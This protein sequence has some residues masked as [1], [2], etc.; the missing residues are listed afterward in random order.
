MRA[1][2]SLLWSS[3]VGLGLL[4]TPC[5]AGSFD[6]QGNFSFAPDASF[7]Q[8][9]ESFTPPDSSIAVKSG[10]DAVDGTHYITLVGGGTFHPAQLA[11]EWTA[12]VDGSFTPRL[13][14]RGSTIF[15]TAYAYY[16][17]QSP[18]SLSVLFPT[19]LVSSDGWYELA[20]AP[21][22]IRGTAHPHVTLLLLGRGVDVDAFELDPAGEA[23]PAVSCSGAF[24]PACSAT[25]FCIAGRCR[26][27]ASFV[28]PLPSQ[29]TDVVA[30]SDYL[31]SRIQLV[32][33][34][35]YTRANTMPLALRTLEATAHATDPWSFWNG[36]ITAVHQL[37]DWHTTTTM[38]QQLL[39]GAKV[40][41]NACFVEGDADLSQS[42]EPS[43]SGLADVLV[44]HALPTG[45]DGLKPGDRLVAVDGMHPI[46]WAESL[47]AIDPTY[48]HADDPGTHAE[49]VERLDQLIPL[50]ASTLTTISCEPTGS[51][52][53]PPQTVAVSSLTPVDPT[54]QTY[55]VCDH[56]PGYHLASGNPDSTT[57]D[58]T[59]PEYHGLLADSMPGENLYGM[60]FNDVNLD[61]SG[62]NPLTGAVMDLQ[63]NASGVILDHR[64]GNG[65][66]Q[67]M[68]Q[69]LTQLYRPQS[70]IAVTAA[71][72]GTVGWYDEPFTT[73]DG[74]SI[75]DTFENYGQD[76]YTV[77]SPMALTKLPVALLLARDGSASDWWPLG[78]KGG[79]AN[80]RLF[81][82]QTAG[83]FSTFFQF[84]YFGM[85]WQLASGD[86]IMSD[87]STRLGQAVQPDE[88]LL[89]KQSDLLVGKDTVYERALA[90]VRSCKLGACQ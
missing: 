25:Q 81:G 37:H 64:T 21:F 43:T 60:I 38:P 80:I 61:S 15:A 11:M 74:M 55:I 18:G 33:G 62:N 29:P 86:L 42:I 19:G 68:A 8:G 36:F 76:L 14:A 5:H 16:D 22:T 31:A 46:A 77:G 79:G 56:R 52:C 84:R 13:F 58:L 27:G 3:I 24:D 54:H 78:M 88:V 39:L 49:A 34:G 47:E 17:D 51:T 6:A 57:H 66:V 40:Q 73:A 35:R 23:E 71:P 83:A 85:S 4:S 1:R 20:G 82:R 45:N 30:A 65:G 28:P 9:F 12:Q 26:D 32:F 87:F 67:L 90:W 69:Y 48:W 75:Y 89:P 72:S 44:S 70:T 50:Y 2:N 7:T 10:M 41:L 63:Q 59:N 53:G